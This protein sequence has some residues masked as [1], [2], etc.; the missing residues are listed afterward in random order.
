[1][2]N[3]LD[4]LIL[5]DACITLSNEKYKKKDGEVSIYPF[6]R[7]S[8]KCKHKSWLEDIQIWLKSNSL[9][10]TLYEVKPSTNSYTKNVNWC[11]DS[12]SNLFVDVHKRW[13]IP[14]YYQD[15]QGYECFKYRKIVPRD[16]ELTPE[17]VANWYMGD[18]NL[19]L[20]RGYP[21]VIATNGFTHSE[22]EFLACLLNDY[23]EFDCAKRYECLIVI[24]REGTR[25]FIDY[26]KSYIVP[27]F[28]YKVEVN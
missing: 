25:K 13:Y 18:G 14:Y 7:Y 1:M 10:T 23:I 27:C 22:I 3:K 12:R 4:G 24:T 20:G 2:N 15:K 21:I 8:H 16:I 17:C 6:Y 28:N 26:V 9:S 19:H 5:G 11:L